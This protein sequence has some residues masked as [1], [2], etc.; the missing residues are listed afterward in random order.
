MKI[1][2]DSNF[3]TL[4]HDT[5]NK[6]IKRLEDFCENL[7]K[8]PELKKEC[9][10]EYKCAKYR[11]AGLSAI[12][13][14]FYNNQHCRKTHDLGSTHYLLLP[15]YEYLT[16]RSDY[17]ALYKAAPES[18]KPDYSLYYG[19]LAFAEKHIAEL[20]AKL[21][22]ANDWESVELNERLGGWRF[23]ANCLR[24]AWETRGE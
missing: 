6:E 4:A 21:P 7:D 23:G 22:L 15:F 19:M 20:E 17:L 14:S 18:E 16:A 24:E 8:T 12:Y 10:S 9:I 2:K 3:Y 11:Y 1:T 13:A 5:M